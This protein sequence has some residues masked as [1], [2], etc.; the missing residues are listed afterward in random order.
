MR[1]KVLEYRTVPRGSAT[2]TSMTAPIGSG[3]SGCRWDL[4]ALET[5]A[6]ARRT[7]QPDLDLQAQTRY[8]EG[9]ARCAIGPGRAGT[10]ERKSVLRSVAGAI[11]SVAAGNFA[12]P[13]FS[14]AVTLPCSSS[15]GTVGRTAANPV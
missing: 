14:K 7:P 15:A 1:R 5:A 6:F 10:M 8:T 9:H 2:L 12:S 11:T 4:T 3:W 13:A